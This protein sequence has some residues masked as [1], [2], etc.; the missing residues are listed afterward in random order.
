LAKTATAVALESPFKQIPCS[1]LRL[2]ASLPGA[3]LRVYL[4]YLGHSDSS[5]KAWVAEDA[6]IEFTGLNRNTIY[7][8][9]KFLVD[10]DWLA[11]AGHFRGRKGSFPIFEVRFDGRIP[12]QSRP[13][14]EYVKRSHVPKVGTQ[15]DERD[16]ITYQIAGDHV[17]KSGIFTSEDL[18]YEVDLDVD[19]DVDKKI[20]NKTSARENTRARFSFS[21][22][23]FSLDMGVATLLEFARSIIDITNET[24]A[25]TLIQRRLVIGLSTMDWP[26][27]KE[28]MQ[29]AISRY[30]SDIW[31]D[32]GLISDEEF[33]QLI[34]ITETPEH[35]HTV[36]RT[37]RVVGTEAATV[38]AESQAGREV[39]RVL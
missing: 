28:R 7:R 31:D 22:E 11:P 37:K 32:R 30:G 12:E 13:K 27:L 9:R 5:A 10:N 4:A 17:P 6:L 25:K 15:S 8:W 16:A 33:L 19:L 26:T 20:K 23:A 39:R 21:E 1:V 2:I 29:V 18:G 24:E 36:D 35:E 34:T 38:V 3:A 14:N